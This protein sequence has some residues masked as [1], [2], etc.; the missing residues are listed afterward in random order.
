MVIPGATW[1]PTS[2]RAWAASF[3]ATR[4]FS[5]VSASLT[6]EPVK[7]SGPGWPTYSGRGMWAGTGRIGEMTPGTTADMGA[8]VVS[9]T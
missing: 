3:E 9:A 7:R 5:M 4:I 8:S 2:S 6:S 1:E